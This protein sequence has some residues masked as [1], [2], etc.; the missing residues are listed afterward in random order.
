MQNK[1]QIASFRKE[2]STA[3]I[4]LE[5]RY[6]ANEP[7]GELLKAHSNHID[8]ILS[9]IW[10]LYFLPETSSALYAVGGYGREEL[11]PYSDIDLLVVSETLVKDQSNIEGFLRNVFDLNLEIG[12]SVRDPQSCLEE[13]KKDI[14]VAT[15]LYERRFI[16]GNH[17]T[18]ELITKS[19]ETAD[20]WPTS[21]FFSAKLQEQKARHKH[22]DD[23][24]Y[25]LEPNV[26]ASPGALRDV[27]TVLWICHKKFN[28]TDPTELVGLTVL[29]EQEKD[30]L[31]KGRD[32]LWW[33]RFGLH[34]LAKRKEDRLTFSYQRELASKFSRTED[35]EAKSLVESFMQNYYRHVLALSEVNDILIQH[36]RE[37]LIPTKRSKTLIINNLFDIRDG[38]LEA[39]HPQVF[40]KKPAALMEMFVLM[41]NNPEIDGVSAAT[42]RLVRENLHLIDQEFRSDP[43]VNQQFIQLLKAPFTLVSQLTRMR[44]YG[45]LGRYIPAF[46][47]VIGQMQHDLFH[48]HTVDAHT[49][50]VIR[51]M[52]KF[53]YRSSERLYPIA[54][55]CSRAIPKVE[56]LY[57]SGLFHDIG[58][59]RGEDHSI[60][61]SKEARVF[62]REHGL[63]EQDTD[64]VCWLVENHLY[65]STVSQRQDI[66]D[67]LVIGNFAAKINSEMRLDYLYALTVADINATNPT[68]W[69]TWRATLLRHLYLETRKMLRHG[70]ETRVGLMETVSAHQEKALEKVGK[71]FSKTSAKDL[72]KHLGNDVFLRNTATQIVNLTE[73]LLKHDLE[74]AP[75]VSI[76]DLESPLPGEGA[77]QIHVYDRDKEALFAKTV[78]CLNKL[79]LSI[80]E[81][82]INTNKNGICFDTYTVLTLGG[83]PIERSVSKRIQ[84]KNQL[85]KELSASPSPLSND[86]VP[87]RRIAR[88]LKEL[89]RKTEVRIS[90]TRFSS[91]F[92]IR[93]LAADRPGLL[94][95]ISQTLVELECEISTAKIITLGEKVEDTFIVRPKIKEI[96]QD[97]NEKSNL[98]RQIGS[99]I[100]RAL[101]VTLK[102]I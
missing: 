51:N 94:A 11:H 90:S 69:N 81:A 74:K 54:Y 24:E 76:N 71:R 55:H 32:F 86:E 27:H 19:L 83:E 34:L 67:P 63:A 46:G 61:G 37:T 38:Y 88:Q 4:A 3:R 45:V 22:F 14:S 64:L 59:G 65:M 89:E 40:E 98:E 28:T 84:I 95:I 96:F 62:C 2:I 52:R 100:D 31:I 91:D 79:A 39:K 78:L 85:I 68:L 25:N 30:W 102:K 99:K 12:H 56:L 49:M 53:R 101:N 70:I 23:S 57:L 66:Y 36:F 50:L 82:S 13:A 58:K 80:V 21:E 26:K 18:T 42:I 92:S 5:N 10:N 41:A 6:W 73:A 7:I 29:T 43:Q 17:K 20:L 44:R 9:K 77:T 48:T 8:G 72:W 60:A 93:I 97:A 75:F 16:T 1:Q 47:A 87:Q 35:S 33:V 15:S